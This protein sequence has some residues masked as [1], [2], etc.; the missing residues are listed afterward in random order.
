VYERVL[1]LW[2]DKRPEK[3]EIHY[4]KIEGVCIYLVWLCAMQYN[5]PKQGEIHHHK[6]EGTCIYLVWFCAM[7]DN[8]AKQGEDKDMG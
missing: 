2:E 3:G 1:I 8:T 6:I 7:Q 4:H 5:A